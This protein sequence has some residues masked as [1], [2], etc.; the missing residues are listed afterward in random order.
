MSLLLF[1]RTGMAGFVEKSGVDVVPGEGAKWKNKYNAA[2]GMA[3]FVEKSGVD[4]PGCSA[5]LHISYWSLQNLSGM[6]F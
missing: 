4:V 2:K 6:H 3:G 5:F 1:Q